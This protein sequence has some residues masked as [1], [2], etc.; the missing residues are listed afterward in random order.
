MTPLLATDVLNP[1]ILMNARQTVVDGNQ[2]YPATRLALAVL[3]MAG[4]M[5][6]AEGNDSRDSR[7]WFCCSGHGHDTAEHQSSVNTFESAR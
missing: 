1:T 5:W 7:C 6:E 3:K 2:S 4:E